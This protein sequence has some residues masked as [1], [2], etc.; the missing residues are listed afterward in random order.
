VI[1]SAALAFAVD[2]CAP[3]LA[4]AEALEV[5]RLHY[6]YVATVVE[7]DRMV[8]RI[9]S[10]LKL[11]GAVIAGEVLRESEFFALERRLLA[12]T[13]ERAILIGTAI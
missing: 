2:A 7:L 1:T 11:Q 3:V 6:I 12:A 13:W 4:L 8:P 5:F 10:P 9:G